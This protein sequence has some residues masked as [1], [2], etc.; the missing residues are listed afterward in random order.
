MLA[1]P[2]AGGVL[3]GWMGSTNAL[4]IHAASFTLLLLVVAMSGLRRAPPEHETEA[5]TLL[6]DYRPLIGNRRAMVVTGA[7]S[8]EGFATAI[9]PGHFAFLITITLT[10][11]PATFVMSP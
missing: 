5:T 8:L 3:V 11:G 4:L 7:I 9:A 10:T 2:V 6:A 1:G